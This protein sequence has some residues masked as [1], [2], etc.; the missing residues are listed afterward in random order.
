[1]FI[2][3][4]QLIHR[5]RLKM[6]AHIVTVLFS[7]FMIY[8]AW[9]GSSLFSWHPTLMTFA[10]GAALWEALLVF[11]KESSIFVNVTRPTKVLVHQIL[12]ITA[13]ASSLLGFAAIYYN[14]EFNEKPHF[15]TWH[16]LMGLIAVVFV[17]I[18]SFGGDLVKY[19]W[20]RKLVGVNKSLAVLKIYHATAGLVAFTLVMATMML[21][22]YSTWFTSQVGWIMWMLCNG[23]VSFMAVIV[24]NQ[25]VAEYLPRTRGSYQPVT[26][27][28]TNTKSTTKFTNKKKKRN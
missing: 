8:T 26:A 9:P 10:F 18:Q 13:V 28:N 14:K 4:F 25:V 22:L 15:V 19:E 2:F 24:M 16:G 3:G 20:L 11:N 5:L 6:V 21:A 12:G 23:C 7:A 1:M 17:T 27:T